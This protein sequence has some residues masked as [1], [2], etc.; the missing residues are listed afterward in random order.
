MEKKKREANLELLR[1]LSMCMVI[2]VVFELP[3]V[4]ALL[5]RMHLLSGSL[6]RRYRRHAIVVIL[7]V[8]A[9]IAKMII[10]KTKYKISN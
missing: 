6:M 3:V 2:G 10:D 8:A 4:C 1:I 9:I 7:I 5:G